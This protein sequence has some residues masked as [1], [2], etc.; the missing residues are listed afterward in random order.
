MTECKICGRTEEE[1]EEEFGR[2]I[3]VTEHQGMLKCGKCLSEYQRESG[4]QA[5]EQE[6]D[7]QTDW[8]KAVTA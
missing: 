8:K 6:D 3:E 4:D 2:E 5:A 7:S 1:L